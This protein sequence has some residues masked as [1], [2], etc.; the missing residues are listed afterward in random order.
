MRRLLP[1]LLILQLAFT[2]AFGPAPRP[3]AQTLT[4][5]QLMARMTPAEKVGQ[6]FMVTFYGPTAETGSEIERLIS[7]QRVGGVAILA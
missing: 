1:W 2:P 6:L 5:N 4:V 7:Q 3:A